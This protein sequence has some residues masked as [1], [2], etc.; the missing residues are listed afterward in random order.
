[1]KSKWLLILMA[2]GPARAYA[3]ARSMNCNFMTWDANGIVLEHKRI[4][5]VGPRSTYFVEWKFEPYEVRAWSV[6]LNHQTGIKMEIRN[7]LANTREELGP[8]T[9]EDDPSR[10]EPYVNRLVRTPWGDMDLMC[11]LN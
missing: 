4:E 6:Y 11:R 10:I 1:M 2:L 8:F 5:D 7:R 9:N 3:D